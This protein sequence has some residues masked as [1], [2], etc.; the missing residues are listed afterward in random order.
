[1]IFTD[2]INIIITHSNLTDF[3]EEINIVVDKISNWFQKNLLIINFSKTY[4]M[5]FMT[6]SK[7]AVDIH[8]R[9][10]VNPI[11]NTYMT[12][13]LGLTLDSTLSSKSN[14]CSAKF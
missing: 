5:H 7:L 10:Q 4:Y 12:N 1:M 2:D 6:K 9:H 3:I 14:I 11:I 8:I 13:F